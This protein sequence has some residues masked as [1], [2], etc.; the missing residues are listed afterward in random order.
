MYGKIMMMKIQS[1]AM[2]QL[3]TVFEQL[4]FKKVSSIAVSSQAALL[5]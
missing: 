1:V 5:N 3:V 2:Y 4:P